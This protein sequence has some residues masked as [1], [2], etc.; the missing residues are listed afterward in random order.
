MLVVALPW[1][2]GEYRREVRACPPASRRRSTAS[3]A[4]ADTGH[5]RHLRR[6]VG[7][8][9][10]SG[11]RFVAADPRRGSRRR[12]R[13]AGAGLI[14]GDHVAVLGP[15]SRALITAV[16]GVLAGRADV[17]G[18]AA[19]DA[20]GLARRVHRLDPRPHPPR[21]RQ[22]AARRRPVRRRLRAGPGRSAH[23]VAVERV[24]RGA[25]RA[26]R[27][28]L[29]GAAAGSR[30]A[31]HPAVHERIDERAEGRDDPRSRPVGEHRRDRRGRWTSARR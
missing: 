5:G 3:S 30:T 22:A 2:S 31:R 29:R 8:A 24:A 10:R 13:A 20:H 7:G 1:P 16:R 28:R 4:A 14:P 27:R 9:D 12:R 6:I 17:D 19:A 18:A 15:T 21:R 26:D 23:G 11:H 25:K